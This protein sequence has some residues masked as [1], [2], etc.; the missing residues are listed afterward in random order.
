MRVKMSC[1]LDIGLLVSKM[2]EML[3]LGGRRVLTCRMNTVAPKVIRFTPETVA[4][5]IA[6][7]GILSILA[8]V[9]PFFKFLYA[10]A[11]RRRSL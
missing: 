3:P 7:V 5:F 4:A 10:F 9:R 1:V 11:V 6:V 2:L 8:Q